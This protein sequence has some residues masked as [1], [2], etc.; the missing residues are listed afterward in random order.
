MT[1]S[2]LTGKQILDFEAIKKLGIQIV[3][4]TSHRFSAT[5]TLEFKLQLASGIVKAHGQAIVPD[6]LKR[7]LQLHAAS[8]CFCCAACRPKFGDVF[9]I[10]LNLLRRS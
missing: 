5:L 10:R 4:G 8:F 6:T 1:V 3:H 9:S 7:E 2:S